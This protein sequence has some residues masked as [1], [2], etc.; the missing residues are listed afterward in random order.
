MAQKEVIVLSLGGSIIVPESNPD[1]KF[2][3]KFKQELRKLYSKYKFVIV[4]GGGAIARRYISLLKEENKTEREISEAGI[5]A[6][7]MNA[8]LLMQ[9]F[10]DEANNALPRD[11]HEV[12]NN[13]KKNN[14]VICGALRFTPKS[15]SDATAAKLANF[16]NARFINITNVQGLYTKDPRKHKDAKLI[17]LISW[18]EFNSIAEKIK[19][20]AG[21]HFVL[22]Q[23]AAKMIKTHSINT[24][25]VGSNI[26]NLKKA[27][28]QEKFTGTLISK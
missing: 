20:K 18:K 7:R 5:R 13:L 26:L 6:T 27:I 23:K 19:Y 17:P 1:L 16:L 9:F 22:D 3:H 25:I 11:M 10:G 8:M 4:T 15:T 24:S 12:R 21:E 2:L 28:K 14:L